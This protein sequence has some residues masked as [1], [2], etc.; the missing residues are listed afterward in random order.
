MRANIRQCFL[1]TLVWV[2]V[3]TV[4]GAM[5]G[6]SSARAQGSGTFDDA[7]QAKKTAEAWAL[8]LLFAVMSRDLPEG[9]RTITFLPMDPLD[10]NLGE[11]QRDRVYRWMRD[12][13]H[14]EG[15][16]ASFT[17]TDPRR[18][19]AVWR[20]Y[21][22]RGDE[23]GFKLYLEAL[24][25]HST[26]IILKCERATDDVAGKVTFGCF[27][28]DRTN[29]VELANEPVSFDTKWLSPPLELDQAL[30]TMAGTIVKGL[31][32]VLGSVK[33]EDS[34]TES[35]LKKYIAG[36]L[37]DFVVRAQR[38]RRGPPGDG[39]FHLEVNIRRSTDRADLR[40]RVYSND[41]FVSFFREYVT[42]ESVDRILEGIRD[43]KGFRDCEVCPEMV[44]IPPGAYTMGSPA[45]EE[46]RT[47]NEGP[48]H[49]V[50]IGAS[51]AVGRYE[52]TRRE[53]AAF[54]QETGREPGGSCWVGDGGLGPGS[55]R[56]EAGSSWRRPGFSQGQGHPVVCVSWEDAQAYAEWL[57][58]KTGKA[59]RLL[60][61]AEWEYAVRAGT[62]TSRYWGDGVDG[63]CTHANGAD[64]AFGDEYRSRQPRSVSCRDGSTYT[65]EAGSR[66][67]NAWGLSD[68]L[69]NAW[70]W[71]EDCL[72]EDYTGA[73]DN[74][75]AWVEG[76]D[77]GHRMLRGG[78]WYSPPGWLR[79]AVR[80][81][82]TP[83]NHNFD[84]GF[85]IARNVTP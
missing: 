35:P 21:E 76:G 15:R 75:R 84:T 41:S 30:E 40:V 6:L 80:G 13:L 29:L 79:S 78:S 67:A 20:A 8:K 36:T 61:G 7:A 24:E 69:G 49:E 37:E 58:E 72:H 60:S 59:Y 19:A 68:M 47:S 17:V 54:V 23:N 55:W 11:H 82:D 39:E 4:T 62:T 70:E 22:E 12:A 66:G 74:G 46:G 43:R 38:A 9:D 51:L 33:I 18:H 71:V 31:R 85:R 26:R 77:C 32:G 53:Y 28:K 42:R 3:V 45:G 5:G 10:T 52:V 83:E 64:A 50:R 48:H 2:G 63:Q 44:V 14:A 16:A 1:V 73:P 56:Q 27:A 81:S 25:K 65:A 34:G 57:S